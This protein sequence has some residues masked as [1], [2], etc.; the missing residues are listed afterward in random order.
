MVGEQINQHNFVIRIRVTAYGGRPQVQHVLWGGLG[1]KLTTGVGGWRGDGL[2]SQ[3]PPNAF[4]TLSHERTRFDALLPG[5]QLHDF[6][7]KLSGDTATV[8]QGGLGA[9]RPPL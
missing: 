4:G 5:R 6:S 9:D 7:W 8:G 1:G 2:D 3:S